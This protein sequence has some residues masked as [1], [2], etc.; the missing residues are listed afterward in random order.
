MRFISTRTHGILDYLMGALLIVLPW[1]VGFAEQGNPSTW[2]LIALGAGLILY[3]LLTDY[4]YGLF[5]VIKMPT[6]LWLDVLSGLFLA[7][8]PWIFEFADQVYLPHVIL[9]L[10]EIGAGL[11]TKS[12]PSYGERYRGAGGEHRAR[13]AGE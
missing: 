7:A 3:S 5:K 10:L 8:S 11:M 6:H 1:L 9:G 12:V 2:V 13:P 4:E